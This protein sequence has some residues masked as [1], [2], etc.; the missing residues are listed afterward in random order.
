M[1][2]VLL[3]RDQRDCTNGSRGRARGVAA[4]LIGTVVAGCAVEPGPSVPTK[5]GS[6]VF[7]ARQSL[8]FCAPQGPKGGKAAVTSSYIASMIFLGIL[9]GA[10][11]AASG[12]EHTR[13]H[14]AIDAVD[15]C[16][17][18]QGFERREL[19]AQEAVAIKQR[20]RYAR[21][22]LLTHLVNGG[23]LATYDGP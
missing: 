1:F 4:L 23:A 22:Q 2:K 3:K 16:L 10:I 21:D 11:A 18:E 19:T 12:E 6:S 8:A 13:R 17:S 14:G 9:P 20:D 5:T 15:D 7:E